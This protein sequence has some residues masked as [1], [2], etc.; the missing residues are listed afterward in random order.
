MYVLHYINKV[1]SE[2]D[3]AVVQKMFCK[4][5]VAMLCYAMLCYAM[6]CYAMLCY[7][8]LCY[9]MLCYAMLC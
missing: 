6:L 4:V 9:A 5:S 1:Y 7:A 2:C 3:C 8:M